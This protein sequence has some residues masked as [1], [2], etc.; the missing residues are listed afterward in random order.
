MMFIIIIIIVTVVYYYSRV[1][2]QQEYSWSQCSDVISVV[3]TSLHISVAIAIICDQVCENRS[4]LHIQ[5]HTF[6]GP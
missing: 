2:S 1:L 6:D 5:L 4:Y 3:I